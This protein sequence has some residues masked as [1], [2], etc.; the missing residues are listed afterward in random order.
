MTMGGQ[1]PFLY[2]RASQYSFSG[3]TD[4]VFDP[5]AVSRASWTQPEPVAR[6][7]QEGPLI[8]AK[9]FNKHP[10]SYFIV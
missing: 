9:E 5:K 2:D 10:D 7:K 1:Q 6:P 3:P 4:K 8:N